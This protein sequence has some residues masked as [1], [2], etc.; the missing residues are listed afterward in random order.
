MLIWSDT[1]QFNCFL[2]SGTTCISNS[3]LTVCSLHWHLPNTVAPHGLFRSGE[4]DCE[5]RIALFIHCL[6]TSRVLIE[7]ESSKVNSGE[8]K[9]YFLFSNLIYTW[10][11][12]TVQEVMICSS[13]RTCTTCL[14]MKMQTSLGHTELLGNEM[15]PHLMFASMAKAFWYPSWHGWHLGCPEGSLLVLNLD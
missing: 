4:V 9:N 12:C 11:S 15:L 14:H 7:V 6:L 5:D 8:V 1:N 2:V 13:T 3:S 10:K